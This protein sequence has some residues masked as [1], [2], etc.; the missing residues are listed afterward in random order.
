MRSYGSVDLHTEIYDGSVKEDLDITDFIGSDNPNVIYTIEH[1]LSQRIVKSFGSSDIVYDLSAIGYF[2][3]FND[4]AG[5]TTTIIPT[6]GT[7]R[8][9]SCL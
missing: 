6:A 8:S 7:M 3:Y 4:L 1:S 5:N 9:T 2:G